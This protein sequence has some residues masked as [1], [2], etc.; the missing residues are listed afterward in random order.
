MVEVIHSSETPVLTRATL[1][2]IPE[3]GILHR[4]RR[5]NLKSSKRVF[6]FILYLL[7][8]SAELLYT[9]FMQCIL[10][11]SHEQTKNCENLQPSV[12]TERTLSSI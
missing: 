11:E 10:I 3:D 6:V 4:H 1:R 8:S 7:V 12:V 5:E 9:I 2:H